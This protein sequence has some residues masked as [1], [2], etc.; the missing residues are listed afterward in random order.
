M[1]ERYKAHMCVG[2]SCWECGEPDFLRRMRHAMASALLPDVGQ[3][4]AHQLSR[5][6]ADAIREEVLSLLTHGYAYEAVRNGVRYGM[7]TAQMMDPDD[8]TVPFHKSTDFMVW[9][10]AT[11][12]IEIITQSVV[13][14]LVAA[15]N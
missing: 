8:G 1:K 12:S 13:S 10:S 3:E 6:A 4:K 14:T 15:G 9:V 7:S 5:K 11:Q 2:P